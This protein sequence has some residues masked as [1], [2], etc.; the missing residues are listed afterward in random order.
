MALLSMRTEKEHS[1]QRPVTIEDFQWACFQDKILAENSLKPFCD[2][3]GLT[4]TVGR[5]DSLPE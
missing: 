2:L 5:D 4:G 1:G 3:F